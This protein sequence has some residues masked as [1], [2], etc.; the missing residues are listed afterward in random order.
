MALLN[1]RG[2]RWS[3]LVTGMLCFALAALSSPAAP[4]RTALS[5]PTALGRTPALCSPAALGRMTAPTIVASIAVPPVRDSGQDAGGQ[6]G[7]QE[8]SEN[9]AEPEAEQ[10]QPAAEQRT[11]TSTPATRAAATQRMNQLRNMRRMA[12]RNGVTTQE[13]P[14]TQP[15]DKPED[16][17]GQPMTREEVQ[18]RIQEAMQNREESAARDAQE[19]PNETGATGQ[20]PQEDPQAARAKRLEELRRRAREAR[21]EAARR[22]EARERGE[23]AQPAGDPEA[24]TPEQ[25]SG[26]RSLEEEDRPGESP[27]QR[28]V[29]EEAGESEPERPR[30]VRRPQT[31]PADGKTEWFSFEGM[32]WEDVIDHFARRIGKPLI[33]KDEIVIGGD[34][35]YVNPHK[36]TKEE[37]IDELNLLLFHKGWRFVETEHHIYAVPLS[38]MPGLVDIKHTFKTREEFEAANP[39]D[40][41]FVTVFIQ[42]KDRPAQDIVDTYNPT[43]PDYVRMSEFGDSNQIKYVAL[44]KDVRKFLAMVD[45]IGFEV[46]DPRQIKIFNVQTNVREI[47]RMLQEIEGVGTDNA[48]MSARSRLAQIRARRTGQQQEEESP[49][50]DMSDVVMTADER[51]NSLIV[52]ATPTQL[53][54]IGKFI[55]EIDK[56]APIGE[57]DTRVVEIKHSNAEDVANA[58]TQIFQQEQGQSA[59]PAWQRL[60]ALRNRAQRGRTPQQQQQNL[61]PS[62]L[63]G[64]GLFER[65]KKTIRVVPF[66]RTNSIIVYANEEGHERVLKMLKT[67]DTPIPSNFRTFTLEHAD[68]EQIYPVVSQLA[69]SAGGG[70]ASRFGRGQS[71]PAVTLDA[72]NNAFHVFAERED[73]QVIEDII[74]RLDIPKTD[75]RERYVVKLQ[76]LRPSQV[77][78]TIQPLLEQGGGGG[79]AAQPNMQRFNRFNRRG[80]GGSAVLGG[81][82]GPQ[83]IPL[84]EAMTLIVICDAE[85]WTKVE[86]TIR[87]WDEQAVT[88]TP[89]TQS[90][91]VAQADPNAIVQTL[92]QFYRFYEHPTLGRSQVDLA[93]N[94]SEIMVRAVRPA[95][96]EI[97][98]M[99]ASMD[100]EDASQLVILPLAHADANEVAQQIQAIFTGGGAGGRGSRRFGGSPGGADVNI[101]ADTTTNSLIVQ[102]DAA[103]LERI[104]NY[105][106][107]MDQK[108]AA[109]TPQRKFYT[110]RYADPR[111]V[112]QAVSGIFGGGSGGRGFRGQTPS[113]TRINAVVAGPQVVVEAPE[114]KIAE[115]DAFVAQLD[116]PTGREIVI[117]TMQLP[118]TDVNSIA[119]K[120]TAAFRERQRAEPNTL[121]RFDADPSAETILVTANKSILEEAERLVA[122]YAAAYVPTQTKVEFYKMNNAPAD[123]AA[124]WL[125][126]QLVATVESKYGRNVARLVKI[127]ANDRTNQ[128]ILNAPQ[129]AVEMGLNLLEQYDQAPE[130][131]KVATTV[132]VKAIKLPGLDVNSLASRLQQALNNFPPR[133]DK[134]RA[135]ITADAMTENLIVSAPSDM[136]EKIDELLATFTAESETMTSEQRVVQIEHAEASYIAQKLQ[137]LLP[138]QIRRRHSQAMADRVNIAVDDRLNRLIVDAPLPVLTMAESVIAEMDQVRTHV[139]AQIHTIGLENADAATVVN[140]LNQVMREKIRQDRSLQISAE[141]MT[142]SIIVTADQQNFEEIEKWATELDAKTVPTKGEFKI[143]DLLNANPWELVNILNAQYAPRRGQRT[144]QDINFSVV[145]GRS[146]VVQAPSDKMAEIEE[147]ITRLDQY[148]I[149]KVEVRTYELPGI[150]NEIDALAR[151]I[152]NNIN[153]KQQARER[154]ISVTPYAN[155]DTLIVTALSEQFPEIEAMMDKLKGVFQSET[156]VTRFIQL[157]HLDAAEWAERIKEMLA[158]RLHRDTSRSRRGVSS[159]DIIADERTN[160]LIAYVPEKIVADLEDVVKQLD[161]PAPPEERV[162][163]IAL[164]YADAETVA[165]T[166][167]DMFEESNRRNRPNPGRVQVRI[168]AE[169]ITNSLLV[170]AA[171]DVFEQIKTTALGIDEG[172]IQRQANPVLVKLESADANEVA[173]AL[174]KVYQEQGNG[175]GR[176]DNQQ[177][178]VQIIPVGASSVLVQAPADRLEEVRAQIANIDGASADIDQPAVA[179]ELQYLDPN[180]IARTINEMYRQRGGGRSNTGQEVQV[181]AAGNSLLVKGPDA[182]V[183]HIRDLVA[184]MDV[185]ADDLEIK[186]YALKVLDA[187]QTALGVQMALRQIVGR[188]KPGQMQP[189]AFAEPTTNTL[190]IMAPKEH[191]P[192]VDAMITKLEMTERPISEPRAYELAHVQPEQIADSVSAMLEAKVAEREGAQ[193][194]KMVYTG[195]EAVPGSNRLIVFAPDEYH[196]LAAELIKMLDED[197]ETGEIVHI[198]QLEKADAASLADS[199]NATL[200]QSGGVAPVSFRSRPGRRG[201]GGFGGSSSGPQRQ[202]RVTPDEGSNSLIV[203]GMPRDVAYVEDLIKELEINSESV[204][205]LQIFQLNNS[206][207]TD[208]VETIQSL[209]PSTPGT[210][211]VSVTADDYYNRLIVTANK[212]RMRQLEAYVKQLDAPAV[213]PATGEMAGGKELYFVDVYRGDPFDIVWDVEELFPPPDKGGPTIEAPWEGNYIKVI[214]RPHEFERIKRYIQEYDARVKV[215]NKVLVTK[216]ADINK[217]LPY[218]Q[219]RDLDIKMPEEERARLPGIVET[220]WEEGEEPPFQKELQERDREREQGRGRRVREGGVEPMYID[221]AFMLWLLTQDT[222]MPLPQATPPRPTTGPAGQELKREPATIE[223]MP[224]G[225]LI[226]SGPESAVDEADDIITMLQED[227]GIGEVIRIFKFKYGDVTAAARILEQMFNERTIVIPQ[228]PQ[229]QQ[230]QQRGRERGGEEGGREGGDERN[231]QQGMAAQLQQL[232]QAQQQAGGGGRGSRSGGQ[233]VRIATD[234]AHNYL[235]VKCDEADL[236]EIRQLLR[237]LDI[238]PGKVDMR[239]IQLKNIDATE[240]AQNIKAVLGIDRAR[241]RSQR[242]PRG[243]NAQQQQLMEVLQQQMVAMQIGGE[244]V[245]AQIEDVEIVPNNIT[246]SLLVS[247]PPDVMDIIMG[248]I[249]DLEKLEAREILVVRHIELQQARVADIL[250]LAQEIFG[251]VAGAGGGRRG[252][253]Q[254]GGDNPAAMGPVTIAG[255]PRTNT[256]IVTAMAKDLPRVQEQIAKL[257]IAGPLAEAEIFNVLYGDAQAIA[258]VLESIFVTGGRQARQGGGGDVSDVR[259]TAEPTTNTIVVWGPPDKRDLIALKIQEFESRNR[260]Q[261]QNRDIQLVHA[262]PV[263]LAEKLN[264]IFGGQG[265]TGRGPRGQGGAAPGRVT[266]IGDKASNRLLVRAPEHIYRQVLEMVQMLDQKTQDMQIR[267]FELKYAKAQDLVDAFK[268]AMQEYV[269]I[270]RLNNAEMSIDPFTVLPDARTNSILAV[271][272]PR[273]FTIIETLLATADVEIPAEQRKQFRIFVLDKADAS[274]VAD[275]INQIAAGSSSGG[276]RMGGMPGGGRRGGGMMPMNMGG[277]SGGLSGGDLDVTAVAEAA[278]NSVMVFGTAEDLDK[279]HQSIIKQFEDISEMGQPFFVK[280]DYAKADVVAQTLREFFQGRQ[281]RGGQRTTDQVSFAADPDTNTLIVLASGSNRALVEEYIKTVDQEEG[282]RSIEVIQLQFASAPSAAEAISQAFEERGRQQTEADRVVATADVPSNA[283]IVSANPANMKRVRELVADLEETIRVTY[284]PVTIPVQ[285]APASQVVSFIQQF[286]GDSAAGGQQGAGGRGGQQGTRRG[287]QIVPNDAG[288]A[289]IAS[290]TEAEI[291]RVRSLVEKFDDATIVQS[292]VKVI[293]VPRSQDAFALAA[294]VERI[295]NESQE[296]IEERTG[297][298]ADRVT[299]GADAYTNSLLVAGNPTAFGMVDTLVKQLGD[300]RSD[301]QVTRVIKLGTMTP[302]HAQALIDELQRSRTGGGTIRNTSGGSSRRQPSGGSRRRGGSMLPGPSEVERRLLPISSPALRAAPVVA[303]TI[304]QPQLIAM[305][306]DRVGDRVSEFA[307]GSGEWLSRAARAPGRLAAVIAEIPADAASPAATAVARELSMSDATLTQAPSL[308]FDADAAALPAAVVAAESERAAPAAALA[309]AASTAEGSTEAVERASVPAIDSAAVE[310]ASVPAIDSAAVDRASVPAIDSAAVDRASVPARADTPA[311]RVSPEFAAMTAAFEEAQDFNLNLPGTVRLAAA[312]SNVARPPSAAIARPPSAGSVPASIEPAASGQEPSAQEQQPNRQPRRNRPA[313]EQLAQDQPAQDAPARNAAA[314]DQPQ[315]QPQTQP[316]GAVAERLDIAGELR[317]EVS[318]TP[319]GANQIVITGDQE[320]VEFI[321]MLLSRMDIEAPQVSIEVF[322]LQNATAA[323]L[324]DTLQRTVEGMIRTRVSTP[325]PADQVEIVADPKSNSLI[326]A[327]AQPYMDMIDDLIV[328]LD[329]KRDMGTTVESIALQHARA[330]EAAARVRTIIE[331]LH[332]IR[333]TPQESRPSIEALDRSNTI[334][335]IGT[336]QDIAEITRLVEAYDVQITAEDEVANEFARAE[337]IWINIEYGSAEDIATVLTDLIEAEQTA[338]V[339]ADPAQPGRPVVRELQITTADGRQLPPLDLEKP[340]RVIADKGTN[341]LIVFSSRKN[342]EALTAL[343]NLFDTLPSGPDIEVKS[344]ALRNADSQTVAENLQTIFDQ[345]KKALLRPVN[346]GE[347]FEQGVMPPMPPGLAAQGLPYDVTIT[348]DGRSNTVFV[349]G[350]KNAVLLAAGLIQEMDK[351]NPNLLA[352]KV[353]KVENTQASKLAEKLKQLMDER[354][355]VLTGRGVSNAAADNAYIVPDDRANLLIVMAPNDLLAWVEELAADIDGRPADRPVETRYRPLEYADANKLQGILQELFDRKKEAETAINPEANESFFITADGRSNSLILSGTRDYLKE[356][357]TLIDNLDRR[358]D[359]TVEF[360]IRPIQLNSAANVAARLQ[361]MVD[362]QNEQTEQQLFATPVFIS[363]DPFSNNLILGAS[364]EDIEMLERWVEVLDRPNALGLMV[365]IFPMHVIRAED[366]VQAVEAL[367]AETGGQQGGQGARNITITAQP[368][369]NSVVVVAPPPLLRDIENTLRRMEEVDGI[370]VA[371]TRTFKLKEADAEAA[372]DLINAILEGRSGTVSGTGGGTGGTGGTGQQQAVRQVM[373]MFERVHP[374]IGPIAQKAFRDQIKVVADLRTNSLWV[375]APP[376]SMPMMESLVA[377]VDVPPDAAKIRI[378]PLRNADAQQMVEMLRGLFPEASATTPGGTART[379]QTGGQG[380]QQRQIVLEGVTEGGRQELMFTTDMRT[381]SV[382]AAGTKGALDIVEEIVLE[383]DTKPI[384]DRRN[385]VYQPRNNLATSIAESLTA[386][387]DA[388][389]QRL[390]ELG[391][392]ISAIQKM[393]QEITAIA[394]EDSNTILISYDPRR[395]SE[396]FDIVRDLDQPPPQVMIEVLI[397]E[398]TLDNSLELGVEFAFQDLQFAKAG[399]SDTTTFDYVGGTDLGAAGAGLGGFTFTITGADFNFLIRTLQNEGNL[400]V[401]S[402]PMIMAMDNQEATFNVSNSVPFV[403]GTSTSVAGQIT[404]TVARQDVGIDLTVTPQ[405]NPDGYVRMAIRQEVS[406]ISSST[407][408]IGQGVTQPIFFQRIADTTVT[409]LDGETVVLGGLIQSRRESREQKIPLFGDVPLLGA[410]FRNTDD[411]TS[412]SELLIV[413]TPHVVR[414]TEDFQE[415]SIAKRDQSGIIGQDILT[416]PMMNKL[417]V[418]PEELFKAEGDYIGPFTQPDDAPAVEPGVEEDESEKYGPK[419]PARLQENG[420]AAKTQTTG[421]DP[422]SYNLPMVRRTK[423][424]N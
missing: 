356:A 267:R 215:T 191:V 93:V 184:Q 217:I 262:D 61:N 156:T 316:A 175:R 222:D 227:L 123:E 372:A 305:L 383:L 102:A 12:D 153:A 225:R 23:P 126:D 84:D 50:A 80:G 301:R 206:S 51:T 193:K 70:G 144:Q 103:T 95:I 192:F 77:A 24:Q 122:E 344:F 141:P 386:F 59:D 364:K 279:V 320:D 66:E 337:M 216:I 391:E 335:I 355:K 113:G 358:F 237:E 408:D 4:G 357:A 353:L 182:K 121:A 212:R 334:L 384:R 274:T 159:F 6:S 86:E 304:L 137:E 414:T 83:V 418:K 207:A 415:L 312:E 256:L 245:S 231:Q 106:M 362:K 238:P 185:K 71:G 400:E 109:Q 396:I 15:T 275:A 339:E 239:V 53:E 270:G 331:R 416:N 223:V 289:I 128:V 81:Q 151:E 338:A 28:T 233:R 365:G 387:N 14:T 45:L 89:E 35:T 295:V 1:A 88:N 17:P 389:Q 252:G 179:I 131:L 210:G 167:E 285:N 57:F 243:G 124:R 359:P 394:N 424:T 56:K 74:Q 142:N 283:L 133:P 49:G 18:R 375:T 352:T 284:E 404:S 382:I 105:A 173:S 140:I 178:R 242:T 229:Q 413:L 333:Q 318:A 32:P 19:Q 170:T 332:T 346:T 52:K 112:A 166:L 349:I 101:Q 150:G 127:T 244:Q 230:Q 107:D 402:R 44:A 75:D 163:T 258:G 325:G 172:A 157:E 98:S 326:V 62:D 146:I 125:N 249:D 323:V 254:G 411:T 21:E 94:G 30:R 55:D 351:P 266:I 422:A 197:F 200:S 327:A 293:P 247:A 405:I 54:R 180:E 423:G 268:Q 183:K 187:T 380:E 308:S 319:L 68:A 280:L 92:Q 282:G 87:L 246:N 300:V 120:L 46:F 181:S 367:F 399:P 41:E 294:E 392:D 48:A 199:I 108:V 10:E 118:G 205:E 296:I 314:Q 91:A 393:E 26:E 33:N 136:F 329:V 251:S 297:R 38:E 145:G 7:E 379:A 298:P 288:N 9:A 64:E 202:V 135:V 111:E 104:K 204:P 342:T 309:E 96:D 330:V 221:H 369:T 82:D 196:T 40:M 211:E 345:G 67:L 31:Q 147:L 2:D 292:Q 421:V 114:G 162:R 85:T 138:Q 370:N 290:G 236:P 401:L 403:T 381:N 176:R 158:N 366:A 195:V 69:Q 177:N 42:V 171:D 255:D 272:S 226:I 299:V 409:V 5:S 90:F 20:D 190:I 116:D 143:I 419:R 291:Q 186:T 412:R 34:L 134:L 264:Q 373:L 248:L 36:F 117:K 306:C 315:A 322:D 37:A 261:A 79:A 152:A 302:E 341:S 276:G 25:E 39:P 348:H 148:N 161:V 235:I 165:D 257:D 119:S 164:A 72:M 220:L 260:E 228:R 11:P 363:A 129:S 395:E 203:A 174:G 269:A 420:D 27:T 417:R 213:D 240:T 259:I 303:Q 313:R 16:K 277:A 388:Q 149:E 168:Q 410:L 340:I 241:E 110:L 385:V 371:K 154:K 374:E 286:L 169:P 378:F 307:P 250:P 65:A 368:A 336:P 310:R 201:G 132:E 278:T 194:S 343:V 99:I 265:G 60:Q 232:M 347:D 155:A 209:F 360:K 3:A 63:L 73:M 317:G 328:K 97:G 287:V 271:G 29:E 377:A 47:E 100:R 43:Q 214:C 198:I 219:A 22:R 311:E 13:S 130:Q 321:E 78:Q 160:R 350:H 8:S 115:I 273:T 263:A 189:G 406:D 224:D 407:V 58:L 397:V 188:P 324:A 139:G 354:Q 234:P 218:L 376:D 253:G 76:N 398:V 361:E 281:Q 390:Q 208:M